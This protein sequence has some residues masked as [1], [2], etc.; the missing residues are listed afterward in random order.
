MTDDKPIRCPKCN[1]I[2]LP[3]ENSIGISYILRIIK[4]LIIEPGIYVSRL[5][6]RGRIEITCVKCGH[7]WRP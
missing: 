3:A 1:T 7:K 4:R 2:Q 6:D 5:T